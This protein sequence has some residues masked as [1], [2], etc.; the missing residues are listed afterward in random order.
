MGDRKHEWDGRPAH[1][2]DG[3]TTCICGGVWSDSGC[4]LD[5]DVLHVDRVVAWPCCL[6]EVCRRADRLCEGI[7]R[8]A[9]SLD[10]DDPLRAKLKRLLAQT[11]LQWEVSD[12]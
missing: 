8:V 9:D 11:M 6:V 12:G 7:V 2:D 10:H 4:D 5:G 1:P 3:L